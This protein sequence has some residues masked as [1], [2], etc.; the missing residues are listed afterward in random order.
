M[1]PE[2]REKKHGFQ[3]PQFHKKKE[4]LSCLDTPFDTTQ[5][6][7]TSSWC[8][9]IKTA[10]HAPKTLTRTHQYR[11]GVVAQWASIWFS[12]TVNRSPPKSSPDF[13]QHENVRY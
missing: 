11:I 2:K 9:R 10:A 4:K 6:K 3:I 1:K 12:Y 8:A 13:M 5:S 7:S